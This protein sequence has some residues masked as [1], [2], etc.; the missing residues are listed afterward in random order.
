MTLEAGSEIPASDSCTVT[1]SVTAN[2]EGDYTNVIPAGALE[3]DLGNNA[4][5]A[6]ADLVV[7]SAPPL[8]PT[9]TKAFASSTIVT[10]APS[11]LT[12]TLGNEN[13]T[14]AT[15]SASLTDSLPNPG[16]HRQSSE[17]HDD[18]PQWRARRE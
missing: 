13:A 2:S 11:T 10:G 7:S 17:R 15:L 18:M 5:A 1:L 3:T 9:V 14:A 6:T 8:P 12:I 16:C 4:D